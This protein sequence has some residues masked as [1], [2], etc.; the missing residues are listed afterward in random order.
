VRTFHDWPAVQA[1]Y[2]AGHDR[3]ACRARFG[4]Q[5]AAWYKAIARGQLRAT[6]APIRYD[7]AQVQRYYDEGHTY[8]QC[9]ARFGFAAGSWTK[10]VRRGNIRPRSIA[11]P[12]EVILRRSTTRCTIKRRL[13]Q[14]GLLSNRCNACGLTEWRGK[15]I[16]IQIDHINGISDDYRLENLRMLCPNCHSQ[17]ETYARKKNTKASKRYPGSSNGRTADSDSAY[18]GSS[19]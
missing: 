5:L 3:D 15:P 8:R 17:I 19:P 4:F 14:A 13:L 9:R 2:D 6:T 12:L 1:Y 10:A 11:L 16:S 18:R 7:W